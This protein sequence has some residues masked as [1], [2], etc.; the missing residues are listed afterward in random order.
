MKALVLDF[1]GVISDSAPEAF[2]VALRTYVELRPDTG[3][4]RDL[5]R[6]AGEGGLS[7]ERLRADPLYGRFLDVVPLGN[8]A[9]DYAVALTAL[10]DGVDLPD[11]AAYDEFRDAQSAAWLRSFHRRFYRVRAEFADRDPA[12]WRRLLGPYP[13][14][15][16]VL[17]R[18]AG[19]VTFAIAT[20]KDRRSVGAL[21]RDYGVAELFREELVLDKETGESKVAHLEYLQ[22]ELE[23]PFPEMTFIDDKVNHLD[24]VAPLGVRCALAVWGYN[25]SREHALARRDGYLLCSLADVDAQ[26]F[27]KPTEEVGAQ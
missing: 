7:V 17:R 5:T 19:E 1:D 16:D 13:E 24:C 6:L 14:F 4:G 25:A 2:V 23:L 3:L 20:S 21:L 22:R 10:E 8:R 15:I 27:G 11:Q 26:L 12:G 18:R 9:E